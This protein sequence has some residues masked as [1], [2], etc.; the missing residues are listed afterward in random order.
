MKFSRL[1][2]RIAILGLPFVLFMNFTPLDPAKLAPT[3]NSAKELYDQIGLNSESW[4]CGDQ[5]V[6]FQ[7]RPG[8]TSYTVLNGPTDKELERKTWHHWN[9]CLKALL[10]VA[11]QSIK[12]RKSDA[13]IFSFLR[14][15]LLF[16]ISRSQVRF[17]MSSAFE[18]QLTFAE[19]VGADD[20][21]RTELFDRVVY[22]NRE[23]IPYDAFSEADLAYW[24]L[25]AHYGLSKG[26]N[27]D[28]AL[29]A[30]L[31]HLGKS[32]FGNIMDPVAKGGLRT[33]QNCSNDVDHLCSWFH[34][35]TSDDREETDGA[36][37]NKATLAV[38]N[39]IWASKLVDELA[40]RSSDKTSLLEFR[41]ELIKSGIEG[42]YQLI[43]GPSAIQSSR[44][45]I[46]PNIFDFVPLNHNG[47]AM[48]RSW[49]YYGFSVNNKKPYF[50][51]KGNNYKNCGYHIQDMRLVAR[52][53]R[54]LEELQTR[55]MKSSDFEPD[56][57]KNLDLSGFHER[58][59]SLRD[60]SIV[61]F[62]L[63]IYDLKIKLGGLMVETPLASP[64][65]DFAACSNKNGEE[66]LPEE[67]DYL[68]SINKRGRPRG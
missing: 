17:Y 29:T 31:L 57:F 56:L 20:L 64:M 30:L 44:G 61:G 55:N 3:P 42:T 53:H 23:G 54:D 34:S 13:P 39:M 37:L 67:L 22:L 35:V 4:V 19:V 52:I 50:L 7:A 28:P 63:N 38:R 26:K 43:Y 18:R 51:T 40:R 8:G 46:P 16:V 59:A 2:A 24:S 41:R 49:L 66:I 10:S 5:L 11:N 9:P 14:R 33:Q 45:G 65:G 21:P 25:Q 68:R 47:L 60:R 6:Q 62:M 32:I 1:I 58:H 36:T 27:I 15:Q 12:D 48:R